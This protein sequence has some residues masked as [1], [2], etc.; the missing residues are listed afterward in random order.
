MKKLFTLVLLALTVSSILAQDKAPGKFSGYMFGDFFYNAAMDANA[1]NLANKAIP[2]TQDLNGIQLR[3]IYFTYDYEISQTFSTRF[4]LEADQA[5]NTS[6]G[7]IGV[8]VKD[9]YLKWKNIFSGSD[10]IF[11]IQ[12]TPAF[13]VSEAVWGNRFLEK[14]IMDLRGIVS[15]RD[16]AVTLK[17][18]IDAE[19]IFNYWLMVGD[20]T[21]NAPET[22][23]YKRY[24][25]HIQLKPIKNFNI[26]LYADLKSQK[27]FNNPNSTVNPPATLGNNV[28][29]YSLFAGYEEKNKYSVG[30]EGFIVS[31]EN[32]IKKGSAKPFSM[33]NKTGL[34]FSLFG[35]YFFNEELAA[36]ARFDSYDPNNDSDFKGDSRSFFVAGLKWILDKNVTISPNVLIETYETVPNGIAIDTSIQPRLTFYY[37]F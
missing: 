17:G 27:Q 36:V 16:L 14:T 19:G 37:Q 15:S 12:P 7:K 26:T 13:E 34:G 31:T 1:A 20:G 21:G 25:A 22:D 35:T 30:A 18:K 9:A 33:S 6:N 23:K 24:Y 4:R 3:R 2:G 5:A 29:T 32:G 8:F 11:G 10:L 28:L